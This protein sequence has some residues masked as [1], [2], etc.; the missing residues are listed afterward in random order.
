MKFDNDFREMKIRHIVVMFLI[1]M[2]FTIVA[3]IITLLRNGDL[4]N[5]DTNILSLF[6]ESSLVF[7]IAYKLRLSKKNVKNL[8]E[9][10]RE[11]LNVKEMILIILFI[12]CI[13]I[14]SNNILIDLAY[15]I[16]PD[17]AN[18]FVSESETGISS[19]TD[20]WIVF[21]MSVFLAPFTEEIIFRSTL[22]K[23]LSKK[24][25]VYIG[26]IVS[27]IIFSSI[28]FGPQ[29][30]GIFLFGILNCM[31]YVKYENILM[32]MF[33]YFIDG[34]ISMILVILLNQFGNQTIVLTLK[35]MI[36]YAV[37]GVGLFAIG[38]VFFVKF[39]KEN[40]VYLREMYDKKNTLELNQ[41]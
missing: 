40:K 5:T 21:I 26:L 7:M 3:V 19:M 2:F 22:F 6:I 37:S 28:N 36:L 34:I 14:G 11:N 24:F 31:L 8:C 32:P 29:M 17:F 27:S 38:M 16:N 4:S 41:I 10:F 33:I 1:I 18:W 9:D 25:N 15:M 39:I 30:V 12:T 13:K 20:Y 35:D 23:R